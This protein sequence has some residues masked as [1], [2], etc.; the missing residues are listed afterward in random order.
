[1]VCG[2][3][4]IFDS[5]DVFFRS[6]WPDLKNVKSRAVW[7][8]E[9]GIER[10][11][12]RNALDLYPLVGA[13]SRGNEGMGRQEPDRELTRRAGRSDPVQERLQ[14]QFGETLLPFRDDL[15]RTGFRHDGASPCGLK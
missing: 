12:K 6:D 7:R 10:E 9:S 14:F 1:M 15:R 4:K 2:V 11:R 5:G 3:R 8:T 13:Q